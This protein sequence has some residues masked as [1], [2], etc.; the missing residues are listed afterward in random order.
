MNTQVLFIQ[1]AGREGYRE[2]RKLVDTL[3]ANLS[4][5]YEVHYP[6]MPDADDPRYAAWKG[7]IAEECAALEGRLVLVGHSLGASLL[8]KWLSE[9]PTA[10]SVTGLFLLA[11]PYWDDPEW[12][13]AEY[14]LRQDF[15]RTLPV[16]LPVFL[17]HC[18]DD[19]VV[20]FAHL[21]LYEA[22]LSQAIIR[23]QPKGGHQFG[24]GLAQVAQDIRRLVG[25]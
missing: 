19:E 12:R 3:Q 14:V 20:P 5:A 22:H 16:D 11:P 25:P 17:Y 9:A 18:Q 15:A 2:D 7:Q 6:E 23:T 1:G 8:L 4:Q 13:T 21:A 10:P 24:N